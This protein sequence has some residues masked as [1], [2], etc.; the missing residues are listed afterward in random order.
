M[1]A[2]QEILLDKLLECVQLA[3]PLKD[4]ETIMFATRRIWKIVGS[5]V[6]VDE[7]AHERLKPKRKNNNKKET[8]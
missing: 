2:N 3:K 8:Q 7:L 1:Q 6:D 5:M 4:E